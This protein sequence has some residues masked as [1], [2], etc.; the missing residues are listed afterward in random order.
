MLLVSLDTSTVCSSVNICSLPLGGLHRTFASDDLLCVGRHPSSIREECHACRFLLQIRQG[1][2]LPKHFQ[3]ILALLVRDLDYI[4]DVSGSNFRA[5][6]K[7]HIATYRA[8]APPETER[9]TTATTVARTSE[10]SPLPH[11]F[12]DSNVP[13]ARPGRFCSPPA[14]V[15][16]E[17]RWWRQ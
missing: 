2:S 3:A 14:V 7:E 9:G 10:S 4:F 16:V 15:I 6:A 8:V 5:S 11:R 1:L 13:A 17:Q 12:V